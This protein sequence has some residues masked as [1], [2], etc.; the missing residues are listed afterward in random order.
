MRDFLHAPAPKGAIG[1]KNRDIAAAIPLMTA[2]FLIVADRG[3]LKAFS[4]ERTPTR[5][6]VPRLVETFQVPE[7]RER[8]QDKVTDQAGAFP[9]GGPGQGTATGER[10]SFD[11]EVSLRAF[12]LLADRITSLLRRHQPERWSFAAPSEING[13]ILD[14]VV[15][16]LRTRIDR[17]VPRDL[18]KTPTAELLPYFALPAG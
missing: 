7:A 12:R 5:G 6:R 16:E 8:Y 14:E 18:V 13:A 9:T 1:S 4:I 10:L 17:N 15:P 3:C 11:A 2:S